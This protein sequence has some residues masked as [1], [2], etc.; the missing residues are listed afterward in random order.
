MNYKTKYEYKHEQAARRLNPAETTCSAA[1]GPHSRLRALLG[2]GRVRGGR[3]EEEVSEGQ[4][5]SA[6]QGLRQ[7]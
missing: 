2:V 1:A 7:G 5:R 6:G 4:V 3:R